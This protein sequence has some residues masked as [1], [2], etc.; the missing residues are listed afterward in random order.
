VY[1]AGD[2]QTKGNRKISEAMVD[3]NPTMYPFYPFYFAK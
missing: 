1:V 2:L 3:T